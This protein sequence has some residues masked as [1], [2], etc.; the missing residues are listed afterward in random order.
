MSTWTSRLARACA[1]HPWRVLAAWGLALIAA[2]VS[3]S[4]LLS[5][6]LTTEARFTAE[7]DSL[8]GWELL[9]DRLPDLVRS[10]SE[11][12]VVRS[13]TLTVQDADFERF[14][15]GLAAELAG[16]GEAR[17]VPTY[18]T[19][20]DASLVSQDGQATVLP[21]TL[22][23]QE[24]LEEA[25]EPLFDVVEAADAD[26]RFAVTITGTATLG[27]DFV[28]ISEQDLQ[29]GEFQVGLP[30]A[31]IILLLVFGAVVAGLLPLVL[32]LVSIP[33][34]LGLSALVG[35][36][37]SLSFFLINMVTAMGLALGID[38]SL[39]VV[40]RYREERRR[41]LGKIDAIATAAGTAGTAVLFSGLS[42]VIGLS[43]L[44][45]VPDTVLRSLATGAVVIG[46]VTVAA[47]LTLLPALLSLLGDKVDA[48]RVPLV[49]SAVHAGE[50]AEGRVWRRVIGTVM[51]HPALFLAG[52]AGLLLLAALPVLGLKTG[53][54]GLTTLP[55]SAIAKQG[56]LALERDFPSSGR[57]EPARVVVEG[58]TADPAVEAAVR[59]I[60]VGTQANGFGPARVS[61]HP[62]AG[63]TVLDVAL[64][65]DP[66][67]EAAEQALERLR[68]D[69]VAPAAE[70]AGVP[71][72]V[73]GATA[74]NVDYA[75]LL[76]DWLPVVIAFVLALTFV[77]LTVVFRSVVLA[78]KAVL[79]NLL[80]VGAA[81]GLLVL[82]F[83]HGYGADLLGFTQVDSLEPWVPPFLFSVLFALSMDYHVFLLS[84]IRE[85]YAQTGDT[86]EAVAHG[87]SS[88]A[89]LIT[90]AAMIIVVV[91]AGFALGDIV[92]FQQ[93]GFGVGVA[94]V[95]DATIVRS[96]VV[97]SSMALLGRWNWYLPGWL[98]W[99]PELQVEGAEPQPVVPAAQPS[100][101]TPRTSAPTRPPV[102]GP[103]PR[104]R[105]G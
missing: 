79:L 71:A 20:G 22:T 51:R 75:D 11:V 50:S 69:V 68:S 61:V 43:G 35:Q 26:P 32:A 42:F 77:L 4:L 93:M 44:W 47:A 38:Y 9:D 49:H 8:R 57:S 25:V 64:P 41:R 23:A 59:D 3:I 37:W 7:R 102:A 104:S 101:P 34:T 103:G 17:P 27:N 36:V 1:G 90:G 92:G 83:Q 98:Q 29:R 15:S 60:S 2:F 96:V 28:R 94:L 84:R 40:S 63:L 89:R 88:T 87:I 10:G 30:A 97:P 66:N 54:S 81:Y 56:F 52:A 73:T 6:A 45:L 67:G 105:R 82:V 62:E 72:Y 19:T 46:L 21:V 78:A 14:V 65:G 16:T 85:R 95:L 18:W 13:E 48:L 24:Q 91:F 86:A 12:V 70:E 53:S 74:F 76:A 55:D 80:S 58:P 31:L 39:F 100:V 99:L 33:V 5:S